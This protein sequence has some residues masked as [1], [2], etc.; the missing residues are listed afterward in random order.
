MV[1]NNLSSLS[2]LGGEL[3]WHSESSPIDERQYEL[4][5]DDVC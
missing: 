3:Y 4:E 1:V 2:K 5:E